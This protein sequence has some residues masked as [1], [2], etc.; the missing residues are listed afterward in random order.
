MN[1][2]AEVRQALADFRSGRFAQ[3]QRT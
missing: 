3:I 1:T 2:E